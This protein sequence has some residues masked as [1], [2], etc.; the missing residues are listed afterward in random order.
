MSDKKEWQPRTN[1][2]KTRFNRDKKAG[3]SWTKLRQE[4][5]GLNYRCTEAWVR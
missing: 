4:L 5:F 2:G 3:Q 1:T